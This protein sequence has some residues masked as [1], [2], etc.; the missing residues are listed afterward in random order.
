M[1]NVALAATAIAIS[2]TMVACSGGTPTSP[3]QVTS[4][5]SPVSFSR[6]VD[7]DF[8]S[9]T[10]TVVPVSEIVNPSGASNSFEASANLTMIQFGVLAEQRGDRTELKSFGRQLQQDYGDAQVELG[11]TAGDGVVQAA[12]IDLSDQTTYN[13]LSALNGSAFDNAMVPALIAEMTSSRATYQQLSDSATTSAVRDHADTMVSMLSRHLS[14][15]EDLQ[16]N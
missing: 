10:R 2:V 15:A 9:T 1:K 11:E 12:R 3:S 16:S 14:M 6:A 4:G 7:G 8:I 13:T 5:S